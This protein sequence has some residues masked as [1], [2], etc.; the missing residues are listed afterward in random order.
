MGHDHTFKKAVEGDRYSACKNKVWD[1]RCSG[2][3]L[4][5][6]GEQPQPPILLKGQEGCFVLLHHLRF[7]VLNKSGGERAVCVVD[8]PCSTQTSGFKGRGSSCLT[9]HHPFRIPPDTATKS[10]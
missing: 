9:A 1:L 5:P 4:L 6:N 2:L 7:L 8:G 3:L 10:H